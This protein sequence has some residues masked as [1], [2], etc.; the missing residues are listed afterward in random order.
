MERITL[1]LTPSG[2]IHLA[3][4]SGG[5]TLVV[6]RLG[7]DEVSD[8]QMRSVQFY[9]TGREEMLPE[10]M[11]GE[12]MRE[13]AVEARLQGLRVVAEL[14]EEIREQLFVELERRAA[15]ELKKKKRAKAKKAAQKAE[16]ARKREARKAHDNTQQGE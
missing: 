4:G 11:H 13:H 16:A 5:V 9:R 7:S 14:R 3:T 8:K 2:K 15:A 10:M 1:L 12:S 6:V